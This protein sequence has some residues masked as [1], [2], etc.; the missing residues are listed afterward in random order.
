MWG[1]AALFLL[2]LL[3]SAQNNEELF[4]GTWLFETPEQGSLVVLL[5]SQG[6]AAYFWGDNTDRTVYPGTWSSQSGQAIVE[7]SDGSRHIIARDSLGFGIT[8]RDAGGRERYTTQAQ[9]VPA[10]ILGQWA[11]PPR[12]EREALSDRDEATGFFGVWRIGREG[13]VDFVFVESDR[14]AASTERGGLRGAWA[15]Q[16]SELH[17]SWDSGH[18]AILRQDRREFAYKL[19][20]P[21]EVI[22][23][24]E[25]E[26]R[27]AIRTIEDNVPSQWMA[28]YAAE[29]EL[30]GD[31]IAF[32]SR[33]EAR[34][35]YRGDWLVQLSEN[36]FEQID[37]GRF[38]GLESTAGRDLEGDWRLQGQDLFLRWDD[39][40][41]EV[42]SPIGRGFLIYEYQ[43]GRPLDG[44]PTRIRAATP[45]NPEKLAE[46]LAGR[47][48]VAEQILAR[49]EA[50]GVDP[51]QQRGAGWGRTFARWVWP[52]GDDQPEP[53]SPEVRLEEAYA[54]TAAPDPW[55]WPFWSER[56]VV[57]S[58]DDRPSAGAEAEATELSANGDPEATAGAAEPSDPPEAASPGATSA[59]TPPEAVPTENSDPVTVDATE[60]EREEKIRRP[61]REWT[62]PF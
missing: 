25:S 43:P 14:S 18:Y 50:A 56:G 15:K 41:R 44:V 55:W 7:W 31:G 51:Q 2:P 5:Q 27:P 28:E 57:S 24:D 6:R 48:A 3:S 62:W 8:F 38:G 16:G 21:G 20:A 23:D 58:P 36:R 37:V 4:R 59:E 35:F 40:M 47:G 61:A 32:A 29:R 11:K 13:A 60:D 54:E 39:G 1:L 19:I 42:L 26:I 33:G 45:A 34:D 10:E 52:F 12:S 9:Q 17:I 46:H 22:E 49:A 53:S 30:S